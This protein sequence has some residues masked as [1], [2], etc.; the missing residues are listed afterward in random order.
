MTAQL[1]QTVRTAIYQRQ[2][3]DSNGEGM[4]VTRQVELG[5]KLAEARQ[6]TVTVDPALTCDNDLSAAGKVDRPGFD[7]LV[8][9]IEAGEVDAVIA[10]AM[11]RLARNQRDGV[12][13]L[14]AAKKAKTRIAFLNGG[15][16]DLSSPMG[17]FV[18]NMM[19]LI[20][21]LEIDTKG[22]RQKLA[23]RQRATLGVIRKSSHRPFG[24][25][26][27]RRTPH[28]VESLAIRDAFATI[29]GGGSVRSVVATWN[30]AGLTCPQG[31]QTWTATT[32]RN[33]LL[34]PH[35]AAQTYIGAE[36][37]GTGDWTPLVERDVWE[38]VRAKLNAKNGKGPG[39]RTLLGG[40]A[41]CPCGAK[42]TGAS[43]ARGKP[44]YRH[45]R[46]AGLDDGGCYHVAR[47]SE[48][49]ND[50]ISGIVIER[51]S[52]DD[53][54]EL[55]VDRDRP[56]LGALRLRQKALLAR[57]DE[58]A[59]LFAEGVLSKAQV[60]ASSRKI[61][62]QLAEVD[63]ALTDAAKVDVLGP[64]VNADDPAAAWFGLDL[65]RKRAV[66]RQLFATITLGKPGMGREAGRNPGD[67]I[68][69]VWRSA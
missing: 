20:A 54:R 59:E 18:A 2:S 33:V 15:D 10:Q 40:I 69:V 61:A 32:V 37:L 58:Q 43:N 27:D 65:D 4:A 38:G 13:L 51:L 41:S 42:V 7:R 25:M 5:H 14:E 46:P 35:H 30:A 31:G 49:V 68:E 24:W 9:M 55:L 34:N 48:P 22:A 6:W 64:I 63:T 21:K 19:I 50:W 3:L 28:P 23:N 39:A 1:T 62:A 26:E 8:A 56:D 67:T 11:D 66:L 52:R 57:A 16:I 47:M 60:A 29:L 45:Q 36:V 17:E 53:A 12:R 44:S